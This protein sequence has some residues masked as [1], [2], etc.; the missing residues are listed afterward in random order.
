[1]NAA[2]Q[3]LLL[4][5]MGVTLIALRLYLGVTQLHRN[6]RWALRM[7]R[8]ERAMHGGHDAP[9]PSAWRRMLNAGRATLIVPGAGTLV[10]LAIYAHGGR[11]QIVGDDRV[12]FLVLSIANP[13]GTALLGSI[14]GLGIPWAHGFVRSTLVGMAALIPIVIGTALSM[15]D[16]LTHWQTFDTVLCIAMVTVLGMAIGYGS[17]REHQLRAMRGEQAR[18]VLR[19]GS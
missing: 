15:D 3:W 14:L 7:I 11:Y 4:S 8:R 9:L 16:A 12:D 5:A 13:I 6:D 17:V 19:G 1:M 2:G 10:L 18:S